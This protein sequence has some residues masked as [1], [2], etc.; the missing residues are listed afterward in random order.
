[1]NND[2]I[3]NNK[4]YRVN[5][6]DETFNHFADQNDTYLKEKWFYNH[7]GTI[8]DFKLHE[9]LD[10][11]KQLVKLWSFSKKLFLSPK[12]IELNLPALYL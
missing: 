7:D 8:N 11:L 5:F 3:K 12:E 2:L 1:M 10:Y 9:R 4:P 6:G